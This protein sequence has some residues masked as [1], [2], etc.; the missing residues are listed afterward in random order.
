[1]RRYSKGREGREGAARAAAAGALAAAADK[2]AKVR[3]SEQGIARAAHVI[4]RMPIPCWVSS[5]QTA[6]PTTGQGSL[7]VNNAFHVV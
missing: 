7:I 3:S 5:D 4:L 1:L 6:Y 2:E